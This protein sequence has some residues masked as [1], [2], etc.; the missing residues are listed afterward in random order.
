MVSPTTS[1]S[2]VEAEALNPVSAKAVTRVG[3]AI[4][5][6]YKEVMDVADISLNS[7]GNPFLMW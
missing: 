1:F 6:P 4:F 5:C 2:F 7:I 3:M